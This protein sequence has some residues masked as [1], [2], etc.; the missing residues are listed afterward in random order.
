MVKNF[1][2]IWEVLLAFSYGNLLSFGMNQLCFG[3]EEVF[4]RIGGFVTVLIMRF[5]VGSFIFL[6]LLLFGLIHVV[7]CLVTRLDS[8]VSSFFII[9]FHFF[10]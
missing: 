1:I 6:G 10:S 2:I 5:I 3:F 4:I 8:I 9:N 7:A